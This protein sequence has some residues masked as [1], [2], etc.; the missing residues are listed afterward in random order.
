M[1]N[2][3]IHAFCCESL[4]VTALPWLCR[5]LKPASV[6]AARKCCQAKLREES[7][8]FFENMALKIARLS[9][10][11]ATLIGSGCGVVLAGDSVV[12]EGDSAPR[13]RLGGDLVLAFRWMGVTDDGL[14]VSSPQTV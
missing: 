13:S 9:R 14:L 7:S 8:P 6:I 5:I 3:R 4:S 10:L 12:L 11:T 1:N 2:N